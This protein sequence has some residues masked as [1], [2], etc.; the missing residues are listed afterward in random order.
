MAIKYQEID[1]VY[2]GFNRD[3]FFERKFEKKTDKTEK[4]EK[5][6][7][8]NEDLLQFKQASVQN[9]PIIDKDAFSALSSLCDL[10]WKLQSTLDSIGSIQ[11][12][13]D[14]LHAMLQNYIETGNQYQGTIDKLFK[15]LEEAGV[16][17]SVNDLVSF[18]KK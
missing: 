15:S 9:T 17:R 8:V 10:G 13:M 14:D 7:S 16:S 5:R 4:I 11:A 18:R 12:M 2:P 3:D 6:F 1:V